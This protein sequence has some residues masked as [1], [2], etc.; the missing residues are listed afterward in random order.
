MIRERIIIAFLCS[1]VLFLIFNYLKPKYDYDKI[2]NDKLWITKV[3]ATKKY[4]VI[5]AGD[6]RIY[7]GISPEKMEEKLNDQSVLNYGFSSGGLCGIMLDEIGKRLETEEGIKTIVLG[8]TPH[9]FTPNARQN[10]HIVREK[11]RTKEEILEYIYFAEVKKI[12]SPTTLHQISDMLSG[13]TKTSSYIQ[14]YHKGGW[15]ASDYKTR[16]PEYAL[17]SYQ[18]VFDKNMPLDENIFELMKKITEWNDSGILVIGFRPPTT[19][20]MVNL[21]DSITG[22][23]MKGFISRFEASGGYWY[24]A[25]NASYISYDGSHLAK[26]SALKLS[27]NIA[28]FIDRISKRDR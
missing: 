1:V 16:N 7:R 15:V 24:E 10:G 20:K 19:D 6:S 5:V 14:E 21:E 11:K 8:V 4:N 12:F 3:H 18:K 22:F 25:E 13:K 26:E 28:E 9:S 17:E 2:N 27:E 23:D